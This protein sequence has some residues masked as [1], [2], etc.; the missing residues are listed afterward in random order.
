MS[1]AIERL[2]ETPCDHDWHDG[3]AR[4]Q[5]G[6]VT[7]QA[8]EWCGQCGAFRWLSPQGWSYWYPAAVTSEDT[9]EDGGTDD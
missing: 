4:S 1:D 6:K 9:C 3:A 2:R 7:G 5:Y 8:V